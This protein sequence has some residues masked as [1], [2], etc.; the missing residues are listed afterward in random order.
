MY[1]MQ[2]RKEF[3]SVA[4]RAILARHCAPGDKT[5]G[6]THAPRRAGGQNDGRR[7]SIVSVE[8]WACCCCAADSDYLFSPAESRCAVGFARSMITWPNF[9][10]DQMCS[11]IVEN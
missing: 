3:D 8:H 10:F 5:L 6:T 4:Q 11:V 7:A 9:D 2:I 1:H